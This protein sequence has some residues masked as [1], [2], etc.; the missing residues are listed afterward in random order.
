V[1]E[2]IDS[3]DL[4]LLDVR[5]PLRYLSGHLKNAVNAPWNGMRDSEGR[6]RAAGELAQWLGAAGL[7]NRRTPVVYDGA[8]GRHG[9]M[10]AWV[11]LY[12]GRADVHFLNASFESWQAE[13]REVFYRPVQPT[14]RPFAWTVNDAVRAQRE[15]IARDGA[16]AIDFRTAEEFSGAVD[17]EGR[18]G[19]IPGA[20][21]LA[22][23]ELAGENGK[24]LAPEAQLVQLVKRLD[25]PAGGCAIAYC[26][27][28]PRAAL[29][30]LALLLAGC[31][32]RLYDGSY[33]D[34][35]RCGLPVEAGA[36]RT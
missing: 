24:L 22:W 25:L 20:R 33:A 34:W 12:L 10:L 9:A 3:N 7:D 27:T 19:H 30:F 26:R 14:A 17:T 1:A 15:D 6:L 23:R 21:H 29:G 16:V 18:P 5:S 13:G 8:D 11:L 36:G 2:R 32:V 28:G 31:Q 4:L 35:V